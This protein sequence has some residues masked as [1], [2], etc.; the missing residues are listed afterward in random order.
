[1]SERV[2]VELGERGYPIQ[3]GPGTLADA[4]AWQALPGARKV[5]VVH[6]SGIPDDYHRQVL[7][8]L[9]GRQVASFR[10][11]AGERSKSLD[12]YSGVMSALAQMNAGRDA[13]V[14]ALG[15]GVVGDLAGFAAAT[16]MRGIGFVQ[17]PTTLLAMVDSSV[18]GKTG[19]NLPQGK[20]LVGAFHQPRAVLIDTNTLDTLPEREL[21]A[22]LAEVV[23]YGAIGDSVFFAW[24]EQHVD[25]LLARDPVALTHA[26]ATSVRHKAAIVVRDEHESGERALL[27]FG[28]TFG[29]ALE[30]ATQYAT[31]LHGEAVA[32]GMIQAAR[33]STRLAMA[34]AGDGHR[35]TR[36]LERFGLPITAPGSADTSPQALLELMRL[37]KKATA[38][39]LRFVLWRG[40]GQALL[41]D[42]VADADVLHALGVETATSA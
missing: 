26:I 13:L 20:N 30:A 3:I 34:P 11:T 4:R 9:A 32:I 23:K 25:A 16:W 41:V 27:N 35:L 15:G 38:A 8:A 22:G 18:G 2:A 37:D 6:D 33:L 12:S 17:V 19:I 21:R 14:V 24:L 42:G 29:H 5:L 1:M 36:L 39:G 28:H 7:A 40:I 31:W 10:I